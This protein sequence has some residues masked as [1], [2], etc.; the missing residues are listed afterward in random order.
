MFGSA[1]EVSHMK[2]CQGATATQMQFQVASMPICVKKT[3]AA[4]KEKGDFQQVLT[5]N[6]LVLLHNPLKHGCW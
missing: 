6:I 2:G 4:R 1:A 5:I 3:S